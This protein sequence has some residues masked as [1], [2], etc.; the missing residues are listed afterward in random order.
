MNLP[1][2][3]LTQAD[4]DAMP[5]VEA[6]TDAA[7][8]DAPA[9]Y[10]CSTGQWLLLNDRRCP[11]G[12]VIEIREHASEGGDIYEIDSAP[13]GE[14]RKLRSWYELHPSGIWLPKP[15]LCLVA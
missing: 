10:H 5:V 15:Y 9:R 8:L 12:A 14:P 6:E 13:Q 3:V 4:F 2:A 11:G 7:S 1:T